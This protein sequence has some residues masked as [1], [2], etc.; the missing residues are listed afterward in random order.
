MSALPTRTELRPLAD[1]KALFTRLHDAGLALA[2]V[3]SDNRTPTAASLTLL[4]LTPYLSYLVCADDDLPTK[5][6]PAIVRHVAAACNVPLAR[7]LV[8][9]D[10]V[11]DMLMGA[12]AGFRLAVSGGAGDPQA[13]AAHADLVVPSVSAIALA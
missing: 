1:L 7:V 5:P 11:G 8:V 4:G 2:V 12:D 9:G 10:T 3:T 6:S 13:L